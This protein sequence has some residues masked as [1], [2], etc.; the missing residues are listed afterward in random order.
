[1]N[2]KLS[3]IFTFSTLALVGILLGGADCL[4]SGSNI[5]TCAAD[6][7]CALEG[8]VCIDTACI[9]AT[10]ADDADCD[11]ANSDS[12]SVASDCTADADCD[13]TNDEVCVNDGVGNPFCVVGNST[14]PGED[15]VS[16]G[17]VSATIDGADVCVA[18]SGQTCEGQCVD[19]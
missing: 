7:D 12:P 13:A 10:C 17:F 14:N 1:M 16:L 9:Q 18:D 15:C 4:G 11:L 19:P 2:K 3:T 5:E 6:A 8:D